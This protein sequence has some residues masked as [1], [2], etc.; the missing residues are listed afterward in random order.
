MY[1]GILLNILMTNVLQLNSISLK[2]IVCFTMNY[3]Q[4]YRLMVLT[5]NVRICLCIHHENMKLMLDSVK[6]RDY[7]GFISNLVCN[8]DNEVCMFRRCESRNGDL[9]EE[10]F[11]G[12]LLIAMVSP[13]A[14]YSSRALFLSMTF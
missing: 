1:L 6:I 3:N 2:H 5:R 9:K 14:I 8:S 10:D 13:I 11:N 4:V 12:P 7:K